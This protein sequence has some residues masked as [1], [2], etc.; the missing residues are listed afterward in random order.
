VLKVAA[1]NTAGKT[2]F[3]KV[4]FTS[5][6]SAVP[7]EPVDAGVH[8]AAST[9]P[10]P[11]VM[12]DSPTSGATLIGTAAIRGWAM[13]KKGDKG[14]EAVRSVAVFV[15]GNLIGTATYGT[16]RPD[17]CAV[18]PG[19]SDCPGVGWVYDL[20]VS[21]VPEG[22]HVVKVVATGTSGRRSSRECTFL[23]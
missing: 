11:S 18:Y 15:D 6:S 1:L 20:D 23:K 10:A 2:S 4:S 21:A 7:S 17:V 5:G 8:P 19:R 3:T 13:E 14:F 22:S 16:A 12:I 9:A